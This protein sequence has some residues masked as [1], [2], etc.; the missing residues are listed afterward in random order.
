MYYSTDFI[1]VWTELNGEKFT[2]P[3]GATAFI[4]LGNQVRYIGNPSEFWVRNADLFNLTDDHEVIIIF[5]SN[6]ADCGAGFLVK[7]PPPPV[8]EAMETHPALA[9]EILSA[10]ALALES[11]QSE[12]EA[13]A[14][15]VAIG[16]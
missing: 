7:D 10:Y 8:L 2:L 9:D 11:G 12:Q 1:H 16:Q 15:A 4:R 14:T 13:I 5:P 6:G 3:E